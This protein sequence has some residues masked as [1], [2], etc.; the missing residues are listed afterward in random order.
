MSRPLKC[1]IK[2]HSDNIQKYIKG[3]R[4]NLEWLFDCFSGHAIITDVSLL[5]NESGSFTEYTLKPEPDAEWI[6]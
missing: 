3:Q 5:F 4:I 1:K 2:I 6:D